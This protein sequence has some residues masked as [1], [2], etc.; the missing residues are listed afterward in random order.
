M[1]FIITIDD[2]EK[3]TMNIL[4][5]ENIDIPVVIG[6]PVGLLGKS[7][8]DRNIASIDLIRDLIMNNSTIELASHGYYHIPPPSCRTKL[9]L[10]KKF[11][12]NMILSLDKK[13]YL[14][15][16]LCFARSE[17]GKNTNEGSTTEYL[18]KFNPIDEIVTSKKLLEELFGT[19]IITYIY[20]GG[21]YT[22]E[23]ISLV[24]KY[25]NFARTTDE[26]WNVI[27]DLY[28]EPNKFLLKS[29]SISRYTNFLKLEKRY[30]KMKNEERAEEIIVIE[31]YHDFTY[32]M[33]RRLYQINFNVFKQ[34]YNK[35]RNIGE[36]TTFRTLKK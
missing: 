14:I 26:G 24:S 1:K 7:L 20:P 11:L 33:P 27:G 12:K 6:V 4:L 30:E 8:G 9:F 21:N 23:L 5:R 10:L 32:K 28:K 18:Q 36:L 35:L 25:Y 29:I 13:E 31:T 3:E 19:R 15:R 16:S 2:A 17:I 22:E 34:H